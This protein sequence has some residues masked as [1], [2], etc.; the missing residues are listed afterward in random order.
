MT[1]S[2]CKKSEQHTCSNYVMQSSQLSKRL[3]EMTK[4][5]IPSLDDKGLTKMFF[6]RAK[7]FADT[8]GFK[9]ILAAKGTAPGKWRGSVCPY[10]GYTNYCSFLKLWPNNSNF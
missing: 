2:A 10:A 3:E 4:L 5:I 7:H 8:K 6:F 9:D 1:C